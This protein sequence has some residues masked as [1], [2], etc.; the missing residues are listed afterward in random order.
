VLCEIVNE[1]RVTNECIQYLTQLQKA[2]ETGVE[3]CAR[4]YYL[5]CD[6]Y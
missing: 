6:L 2:I 4:R 5:D 3:G 1:D